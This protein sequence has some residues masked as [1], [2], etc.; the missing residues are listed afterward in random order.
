MIKGKGQRLIMVLLVVL[1][2]LPAWLDPF[3]DAVTRGNDLVRKGNF[4]EARAAYDRAEGYAPHEEAKRRLAFNRGNL[5]YRA[6][7]FDEASAW[8]RKALESRNEDVKKKAFFN[9]GNARVKAGDYREAIQSY[10]NALAMDPGYMPAK[11]N[12][13]YLLKKQEQKNKQDKKKGEGQGDDSGDQGKKPRDQD[14]DSRPDRQKSQSRNRVDS[15]RSL[16]RE[17]LQKLLESMKEKPV[18]R[19]KGDGGGDDEPEKNW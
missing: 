19:M 3:R 10:R 6:G 17:Q 9:L 4:Q 8:Y 14:D 1:A 5:E 16:S 11:K 12:L 15:S 18:R 13:E 7:R 2:V